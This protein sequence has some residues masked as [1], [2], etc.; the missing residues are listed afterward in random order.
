MNILAVGAHW[1]DIELGCFLT[2]KHL[3]SLGHEIFSIVMCSA[4]YEV[5][6]TDHKGLLEDEA[7]EAG[8]KAFSRFGATYIDT[9]KAPNSR[10]A[11]SRE[12]MQMLENA[13]RE[14]RIDAVF[15]HWHGDLNTDHRATW[16]NSRTAFR[17]VKNM[18][19]YQSNS[20]SDYVDRYLPNAFHGFTSQEYEA[21]KQALALYEKEW[22]YRESR[23]QGEIFDREKH[24]GY[25]CGHDYAEAF[26]VCKL[27]NAYL[28]L[29]G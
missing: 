2:L 28:P 22:N 7:R 21:K 15:T 14:Y 6:P 13:A 19:M 29:Q 27:T 4:Y 9:P 16:D 20:Y 25:L 12:M 5:G 17:R 11:Y 8:M 3:K 24:W 10:L 23:W 18:Y 26:Q 1:D